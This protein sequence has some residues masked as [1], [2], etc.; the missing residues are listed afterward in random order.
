MPKEA[1]VLE[2]D[3]KK[4]KQIFLNLMSNAV[5]FTPSGGK[6]KVTGWHD[7]T[8]DVYVFQVSDTGI[9]IGQKDIAK[10]MAPFGQVDSALSKKY[11]GTGLGLPLTRKFIELMGGKFGMQSELN[12]GTTITFSLPRVFKAG[13]GIIF[14]RA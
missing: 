9:G 14:K 10:A 7:I 6:V 5:K 12:I 4:L 8:E 13:D 1:F 3:A 2:T 11:E